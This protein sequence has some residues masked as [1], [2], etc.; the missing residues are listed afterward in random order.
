VQERARRSQRMAGG[1]GGLDDVAGNG[2]HFGNGSSDQKGNG[3]D[4]AGGGPG[5]RAPRGT[6]PTVKETPP[7]PAK[8]EP[9]SKPR[10]GLG[11]QFGRLG[12]A[13]SGRGKRA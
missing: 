6:V 2:L 4:G 8:P 3:P 5:G 13:V 1:P 10:S 11:R 9:V 7:P 12:G